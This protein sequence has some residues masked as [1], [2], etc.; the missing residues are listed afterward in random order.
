MVRSPS[1]PATTLPVPIPVVCGVCVCVCVCVRERE[2]ERE[3]E[4][5]KERE[6][7]GAVIPR[8]TYT[9]T[10]HEILLYMRIDIGNRGK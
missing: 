1:I 2:R 8:R 9:H 10:H 3:R 5:K 7:W 4:R 6:T